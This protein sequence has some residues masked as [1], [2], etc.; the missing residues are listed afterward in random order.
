VIIG[1][2]NGNT[3]DINGDWMG[4][5]G[6]FGI[7]KS[8]RVIILGWSPPSASMSHGLGPHGDGHGIGQSVATSPMSH[9]TCLSRNSRKIIPEN[10]QTGQ[11]K[12][13]VNLLSIYG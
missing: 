2:F 8:Y 11:K 3:L 10:R 9:I 6:D 7:E 12:Y 13:M 5:H 1:R 4:F